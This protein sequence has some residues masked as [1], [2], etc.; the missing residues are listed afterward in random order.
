MNVLTARST[1]ARANFS[2]LPASAAMVVAN[3]SE[4]ERIRPAALLRIC[5]RLCAGISAMTV[6]AR[7]AAAM[8]ASRSSRL[9]ARNRRDRLAGVLVL[10]LQHF[11]PAPP[12]CRRSA[13]GTLRSCDA[14]QLQLPGPDHDNLPQRPACSSVASVG[15]AIRRPTRQPVVFVQGGLDLFVRQGNACRGTR[16]LQRLEELL[17]QLVLLS[18]KALAGIE[19]AHEVEPP[20]PTAMSSSM[21]TSHP[22][23]ALTMSTVSCGP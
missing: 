7:C 21:V 3:S 23:T 14:S 2:A 11:F 6:V 9:R 15:I 19:H 22:V 17:R 4:R 16:A 1:S 8:A 12:T 10:H 18:V 20:A 13:V 5:E